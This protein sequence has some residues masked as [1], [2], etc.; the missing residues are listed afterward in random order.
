MTNRQLFFC[1]EQPAQSWAFKCRWMLS[2]AAVASLSPGSTVEMLAFTLSEKISKYS[3]YFHIFPL[4]SYFHIFSILFCRYFIDELSFIFALSGPV[5]TSS[6]EVC[7]EHVASVLGTRFT[8]TNAPIDKHFASWSQCRKLVSIGG[9]ALQIMKMV[10]P[11]LCFF[12]IFWQYKALVLQCPESLEILTMGLKWTERFRKYWMQVCAEDETHDDGKATK[13]LQGTWV[14]FGWR[15][16]ELFIICLYLF[17][18][19][20][21][22]EPPHHIPVVLFLYTK[23][24]LVGSRSWFYTGLFWS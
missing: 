18:L 1:I 4:F 9:S 5:L 24:I 2:A 13:A 6:N 7:G 10:Q 19:H 23:K 11:C 16:V 15:Q 8:K 20:H 21:G 3:I 14:S 22:Y 12:G 17:L